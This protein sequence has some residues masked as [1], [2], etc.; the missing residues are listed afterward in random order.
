[1]TPRGRVARQAAV[2]SAV[3]HAVVLLALAASATV[4][5]GRQHA[6]RGGRNLFIWDAAFYRSIAEHGYASVGKAG[7]RFFPAFPLL[8]RA[9]AVLF[10]G[11]Y[12]V[13]VIV[14]AW[15]STV[16]F[17]YFLHRIVEFETKDPVL[18]RRTVWLAALFPAAACLT[19]GYAE[20]MFMAA[21]V[22]AVYAARRHAWIAGTIAAAIAGAT[23]P[24]GLMLCLPIAIE[25]LIVWRS[26]RPAARD[27]IGSIIATAGA[28]IGAGCF[29]LWSNATQH[30]LLLPFRVQNDKTLRGGFVDPLVRLGRG[31]HDLVSGKFGSGLHVV[32]AFAFIVVLIVI[33][34]RLPC[35][36]GAYATVSLFVLLTGSNLD[37]FE[38]YVF[39][40]FPF[41]IG[42]A[43]MIPK[44]KRAWAATLTVATAGLFAYSAMAFL[45][46]SAP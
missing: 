13:A 10:G 28:A 37:S 22:G 44:E 9:P 41:V 7:L 35:A 40:T 42:I 12:G 38:R 36:Y 6:G 34:R 45:G 3:S 21:A 32:W 4:L 23:R 27:R 33:W 29:L 8:S 19:L 5:N 14:V 20:A 16:V 18:A 30:D 26:T 31:L 24:I 39:S 1:V 15:I 43:L 11:A 17:L 2:A 46:I 25:A